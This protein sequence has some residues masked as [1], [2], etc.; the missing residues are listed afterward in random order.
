MLQE[1][2]TN[3]KLRKLLDV[4]DRKECLD[5]EYEKYLNAIRL[6]SRRK[7]NAETLRYLEDIGNISGPRHM[8]CEN[9]T[10]TYG[11][12]IM[13]TP[14]GIPPK[15]AR[16]SILPTVSN[17]QFKKAKIYGGIESFLLDYKII[18]GENIPFSRG[19]IPV[20]VSSIY[21]RN[22]KSKN[23]MAMFETI[24]GSSFPYIIKGAYPV[25]AKTKDKYGNEID[26]IVSW[27]RYNI[28][29]MAYRKYNLLVERKDGNS[30]NIEDFAYLR[31]AID[32]NDHDAEKQDKKQDKVKKALKNIS[33]QED[34]YFNMIKIID[35][36]PII[37]ND[38]R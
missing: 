28:P 33:M 6:K 7:I 22:A 29:I 25:K 4:M 32:T 17:V 18:N 35:V 31:E 13:F 37:Y 23:I 24:T 2:S 26:L 14:T 12:K 21:K 15:E 20:Y 38:G 9:G 34:E 11:D 30:N 16:R 5:D 27:E 36:E 8:I 3:P 10:L 1:E 19:I